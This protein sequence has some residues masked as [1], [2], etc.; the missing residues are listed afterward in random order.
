MPVPY[1]WDDDLSML[2]LVVELYVSHN[3]NF[4]LDA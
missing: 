4:P 3:D 1:I 2:K